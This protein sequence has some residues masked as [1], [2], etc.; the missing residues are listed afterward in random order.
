MDSENAG[1][2]CVAVAVTPRAAIAIAGPTNRLPE[3]HLIEIAQQI[4]E[5]L[6]KV[7]PMGQGWF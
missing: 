1:I 6:D 7:R 2:S 5:E 4:R 3:L